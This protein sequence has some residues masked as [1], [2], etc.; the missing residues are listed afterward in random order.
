M[1]YRKIDHFLLWCVITP[2][3][4]YAIWTKWAVVHTYSPLSAGALADFLRLHSG[5]Y[6]APLLWCLLMLKPAP[7]LI[8]IRL[9]TLVLVLF[10]IAADMGYSAAMYYT[11]SLA[12]FDA[13]YYAA[14]AVGT[15]PLTIPTLESLTLIV[16]PLTYL[17]LALWKLRQRQ[18][19]QNFRIRRTWGVG[20][21]LMLFATTVPPLAPDLELNKGRPSYVYQIMTYADR[22][23]IWPQAL[24]AEPAQSRKPVELE[25]VKSARPPNLVIIALESVGADAIGPY[26]PEREAVT[27]F[28]NHLSRHSWL[29]ENAYAVVPH[30]S[31]A[32]A[33]INCGVL[34]YLK[35]PIFESNYGMEQPCLPALLR[36]QGYHTAFF[37][38]PTE[39]FENR[40]GLA[41][42]MGFSEFRAGEQLDPTGFQ[43][44]NYFGYEDNILLQ[45]SDTWVRAQRHPFFAFYLTGTTHHP[46]WV[47]QR[48][49]YQNFVADNREVND[50]LNAVHYLDHFVRALLEQYKAAGLY[51]NTVF[52]IVGDH[53]E[54]F[55]ELHSRKQHNASVY[56]EVMRV[57]LL[58][59]APGRIKGAPRT[60]LASQLD[61]MPTVLGLL[62]FEW[63]GELA[64]VNALDS[65]SQ[66]PFALANCWYDD[67]C[68][69]SA[70]TRFK[71][72]HNFSQKGDELYD[73]QQDPTEQHN[74]IEQ[75][76]D[77]AAERLQAMLALRDENLAQWHR[78]LSSLA[79]DY[80]DKRDDS[81]GTPARLLQL[82]QDDPRRNHTTH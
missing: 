25:P 46:Y 80:W 73:L 34:P 64:G 58:V 44:A 69:A 13:S 40:R 66:R 57:P 28:L 17:L 43:L 48:Y 70:D 52:V 67:W 8:G 24:A 19:L 6:L 15:V 79:P 45:P 65:T 18:R 33:S 72:I 29:A 61:I 14:R 54:S 35:H 4:L 81:L 10:F 38:S 26:N 62:G 68:L 78:Y 51:D 5:Y 3:L 32:L 11:G 23:S 21:V 12:P 77:W 36:E 47:P 53:G 50:Y 9:I 22:I 71:Y 31:K 42:Q 1:S 75:H 7:G 16:L 20:L 41:T 55:G 56:Q 27:P 39:H 2:A 59:H 82:A 49:P 30:T 76:R 74:I 37:Q 60:P 63:N